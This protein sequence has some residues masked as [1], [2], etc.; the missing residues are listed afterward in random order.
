MVTED[1]HL[2][3]HTKTSSV[4]WNWLGASKRQQLQSQY[5]RNNICI[6]EVREGSA[7]R[8]YMWPITLCDSVGVMNEAE[9]LHRAGM[10]RKARA[11]VAYREPAPQA[12]GPWA[13]TVKITLHISVRGLQMPRFSSKKCAEEDAFLPVVQLL[14]NIHCRGWLRST[15]TI[16]E[17]RSSPNKT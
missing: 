11:A 16:W 8:Y 13:L 17:N 5:Q 6:L 1:S 12:S 4:K 7:A 3:L 10:A 2:I 9:K 15:K 14:R